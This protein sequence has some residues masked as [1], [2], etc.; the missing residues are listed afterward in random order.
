MSLRSTAVVSVLVL[1]ALGTSA[2]AGLVTPGTAAAASAPSLVVQSG[3]PPAAGP[4]PAS[5]PP[6]GPVTVPVGASPDTILVDTANETAFVGS[7]YGN[8]VTA[9]DLPTNRVVATI[10]VG[11]EPYP[12]AMAIDTVN[13]TL[14]VVNSGSS[15]VSVISIAEDYVTATVP[16]GASPDAIAINTANRDIYVANGGSGTVSIIS[17]AAYTPRVIDTVPVGP[18]PDGLAVDTSSHNVFVADAGSDNISVISERTNTVIKSITVGTAPG[19]FGTILYDPATGDVYVANAGSG[20]V[21]VIGGANL[22]LFATVPVG[23]GPSGLV[24]DSAAK[25]LF[26]ANRFSDNVSVIAAG[27]HTVVATIPVGSQ[28]G[29]QGAIAFNPSNGAVYVANAG[30]DNV[31]IISAARHAVIATVPVGSIPVAVATDPQTDS[32]FV[33]NQGSSSVT[34]F[35]LS[36]VTFRATGLPAGSEWTITAGIPAYTASNKTVHASGKIVLLLSAGVVPFTATPPAGYAISKVTGPDDPT[37]DSA[38][39][40]SRP[41]TF[42]IQ[43]GP[44]EALTFTEVGLPAHAE[45][46]IAIHTALRHGGPGPQSATSTS[47]TIEFSVVKGAWKFSLTESPASY[48]THSTRGSI[49]VGPRPATKTLRFRAI[50]AAVLFEEAGLPAGKS[51]Q[52]NVS[53]PMDV[54]LTSTKATIDFALI[55]GTYTYEIWNFSTLHPQP[56]TGTFTVVAPHSTPL[57]ITVSYTATPSHSSPP[58]DRTAGAQLAP[59]LSARPARPDA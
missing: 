31:S 8:N 18:D 9:I 42:V 24:L 59:V 46:G 26:V 52:V 21:S 13:W 6:A 16:V 33:A 27:N 50:T 4:A 47:T 37:Q 36:Q 55:G 58:A 40:T 57:V 2:V 41:A 10:P 38:N 45:W 48:V 34:V 23:S 44:I 3:P 29:T 7:E 1:L 14:Y 17:P 56:E 49:S 32:V 5:S 11:S 22:T 43:F 30:S 12:Q 54:N 19:A 51:W 25:E 39:V 28:P 15:N 20:N 53:G 35:L